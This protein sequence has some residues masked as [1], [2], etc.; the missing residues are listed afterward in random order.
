MVSAQPYSNSNSNNNSSLKPEETES[1]PNTNDEIDRREKPEI[2][3]A[4]TKLLRS[5]L[6]PFRTFL[7]PVNEKC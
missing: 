5:I 1:L 4:N 2:K 6:D 7:H 3:L